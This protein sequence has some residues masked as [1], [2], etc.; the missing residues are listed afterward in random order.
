MFGSSSRKTYVD[1]AIVSELI[2][3]FD[4]TNTIVKAFRI[5]RDRFVEADGARVRLRLVGDRS[6]RQYSKVGCSEIAGLI[7]GDIHDLIN[8]QDIVIEHRTGRLQR[9]N[10][11]YPSFMP[12]Q[13]PILFPYGEDGFY[14][15]I[16]YHSCSTRARTRKGTMTAREYYAYVIQKR[17]NQGLTLLK[18]GRLFHQYIVDSFT[19][20]EGMRL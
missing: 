11:L 6:N 5:A 7:V 2:A 19:S 14:L 9:I 4:E 20:I 3:M 16:K 8:R 13:Y 15:G 12:M 10:D 18:G 1:P 17:L